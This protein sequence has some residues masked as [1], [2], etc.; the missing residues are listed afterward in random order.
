MSSTWRS[1][2]IAFYLT[3]YRLCVRMFLHQVYLER[4]SDLNLPTAPLGKLFPCAWWR[5]LSA[6]FVYAGVVVAVWKTRPVSSDVS[7]SQ[8]AELKF[9]WSSWKVNRIC[10]VGFCSWALSFVRAV[11]VITHLF[12]FELL[13]FLF[14]ALILFFLWVLYP[15]FYLLLFTVSLGVKL[16]SH[17]SS[18]LVIYIL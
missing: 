13:Y 12:M 11:A 7:K 17:H 5:H 2:T 10:H 14:S 9:M 8:E 18:I 1:T 16:I 4:R 3:S 15:L 6:L